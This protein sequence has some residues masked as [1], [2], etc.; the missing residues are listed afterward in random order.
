[1]VPAGTID[2]RQY[3]FCWHTLQIGRKDHCWG[4]NLPVC[5]RFPLP[6]IW[7]LIQSNPQLLLAQT[8]TN[9]QLWMD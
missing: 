8:V 3:Q 1:M 2:S 6:I 4:Q 7:T 9:G 5:Q